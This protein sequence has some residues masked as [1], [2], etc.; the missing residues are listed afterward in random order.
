MSK[1]PPLPASPDPYR[2][3]KTASNRDAWLAVRALLPLLAAA[4]DPLPLAMRFAIAGNIIDYGA[5]VH[6]DV[7]AVFQ[8]LP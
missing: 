1:S 2:A 6:F 3:I 5:A 7:E 4:S 8:S